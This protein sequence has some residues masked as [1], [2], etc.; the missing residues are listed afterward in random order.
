[1]PDIHCLHCIAARIRVDIEEVVAN[2][3]SDWIS[4]SRDVLLNLSISEANK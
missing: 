4:A 1:M 3:R 2:S